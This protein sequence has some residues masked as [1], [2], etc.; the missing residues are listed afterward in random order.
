MAAPAKRKPLRTHGLLV[1]SDRDFA[2]VQRLSRNPGKPNP[3]ALRAIAAFRRECP[4]SYQHIKD[5]SAG[6]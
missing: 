1:L 6:I 5:E 3:A 4:A 2:K